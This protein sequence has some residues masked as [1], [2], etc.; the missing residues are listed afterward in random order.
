MCMTVGAGSF[1]GTLRSVRLLMRRMEKDGGIGVDRVFFRLFFGRGCRPAAVVSA[2]AL[3]WCAVGA[4]ISAAGGGRFRDGWLL[5][6]VQDSSTLR[7]MRDMEMIDER[8]YRHAVEP[9]PDGV[10]RVI[11]IV[12]HAESASRRYAAVLFFTRVRDIR[13]VPVLRRCLGDWS[14]RVRAAAAEAL[15]CQEDIASVP[16]LIKAMR[17]SSGTARRSIHSALVAL[18]GANPGPSPEAWIRWVQSH[19][20]PLGLSVR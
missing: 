2:V 14:P 15:A 5:A 16:S 19:K 20:K 13:S 1:T 17:F 7:L 9:V 4:G 10:E 6:A 11:E 18:C 3:V 8:S 12:E